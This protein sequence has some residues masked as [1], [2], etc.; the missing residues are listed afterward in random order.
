[1]FDAS[2]EPYVTADELSDAF[3]VSKSTMSNKAKLVRDMLKISHFSAEFQRADLVAE[4][5]AVWFIQVDGLIVDARS[6][7]RDLQVEAYL[8]G[9]IPYAPVLGPEESAA[10]RPR[11]LG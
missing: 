10:L 3:G 11:F 4:N 7:P 1:M 8:R 9:L 2:R 6:V 5:P